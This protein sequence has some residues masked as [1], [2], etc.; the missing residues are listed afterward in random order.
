[1]EEPLIP[2]LS[3]FFPN[4]RPAVGFGTIKQ[5]IPLC[6]FALSVVAN[7]WLIKKKYIYAYISYTPNSPWKGSDDAYSKFNKT[8]NKTK[9]IQ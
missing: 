5:L 7:T 9:H 8:F 3:S 1:M 6:F 4:V 2:S